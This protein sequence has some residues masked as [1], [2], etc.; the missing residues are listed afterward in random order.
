[1][2]YI[3][4]MLIK[5]FSDLSYPVDGGIIILEETTPIRIDIIHHRLKVITQ[6][7]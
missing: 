2:V 4:F 7:G 1:M 6:N 3:V 5:P